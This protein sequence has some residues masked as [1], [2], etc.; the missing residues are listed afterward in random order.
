[1]KTKFTMI[2]TLFTALIVQ[3]TLAQKQTVSGN[4]LDENGFALIGVTVVISGISSVKTT[5]FDG[6]YLLN[7]DTG[8]VLNFS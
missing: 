4:V 8:D 1:M 6:K 3:V 2:L 7:A 5:D